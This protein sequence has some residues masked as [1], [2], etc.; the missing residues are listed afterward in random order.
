MTIE[1]RKHLKKVADTPVSAVLNPG[2]IA[3]SS[4]LGTTSNSRNNS[5]SLSEKLLPLC[6]RLGLPATAMEAI[7]RNAE[8][9][10]TT[11]GAIVSV[12][13]H[14]AAARIIIC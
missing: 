13:G 1:Q 7:A 5:L 10:L 9:I 3:Y 12:P 8:E 14:P 2:A 6:P 4:R 11:D